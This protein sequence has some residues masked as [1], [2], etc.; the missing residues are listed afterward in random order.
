MR[1]RSTARFVNGVLAGFAVAFFCVHS[2]LGGL[3][4]FVSLESPA[5]W[6]LWCG[7]GVVLV[8]VAVSVVTSL[9]QLTDADFPPSPRKKRHLALKW[10]T[11]G[12]LA[13]TVLAH[14][15]CIRTLGPDAVQASVSGAASLRF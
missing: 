4:G 15:A 9:G 7:I 2:L 5:E 1:K 12:V 3:K 6:V 10:A 8:H 13:A 14:I 11:G